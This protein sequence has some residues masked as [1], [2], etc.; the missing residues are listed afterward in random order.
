MQNC[1]FCQIVKGQI[2]C[3]KVYEDKDFLGFLDINPL[4]KGH[5]LIAPKKHFRWVLDV[6]DFGKYWEIAGRVAKAMIK[7]LSAESINFVT[8]GYEI[9]HAHIHVIPRFKDDDLGG[10]ID[11]SKR[12]KFSEKKMK[13]IAEKIKYQ[14]SE[15]KE[16]GVFDANGGKS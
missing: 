1:I 11:W 3:Y 10:F 14:L 16:G 7:A 9:P 5:S 13:E 6:C 8:L 4:N 2:P 12:K 15:D